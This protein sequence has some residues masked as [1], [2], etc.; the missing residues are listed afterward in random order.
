LEV[1]FSLKVFDLFSEGGVLAG[2]EAS[3]AVELVQHFFSLNSQIDMFG[4]KELL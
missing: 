1:E 4:F 2:E 3:F